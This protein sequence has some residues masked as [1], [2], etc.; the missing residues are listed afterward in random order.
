MLCE[1]LADGHSVARTFHPA[2]VNI[3]VLESPRRFQNELPIKAQH[4]CEL[5]REEVLSR[6]LKYG[7]FETSRHVALSVFSVVTKC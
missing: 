6:V 1:S 2:N 7:Q 5:T 3:R 4:L